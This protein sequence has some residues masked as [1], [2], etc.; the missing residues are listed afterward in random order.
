[1]TTAEIKQCIANWTAILNDAPALT[2]A[3]S[4]GDYFSYL[5]PSASVTTGTVHA[6]PG[7]V[8]NIL[9]FFVIPSQYDNATSDIAAHTVVCPLLRTGDGSNRIPSKDAKVR[10]DRWNKNYTSWVTA[11]VASSSGMF[12]AFNIDRQDFEV[13]SV[14]MYLGLKATPQ[15][16]VS[17][18][19]DL[20]VAN[21]GSSVVYDDYVNP[22]PPY[23]PSA[24]VASFYLL[25]P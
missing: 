16:E 4:Q 10:I 12:Q 23:G 13:N 24:A 22:V 14:K 21:Q 18:A 6:Y 3:L 7:L 8:G 2:T 9:N 11:Q 19:A 5:Y 25:Q 1:M 15:A 17:Y 20:I